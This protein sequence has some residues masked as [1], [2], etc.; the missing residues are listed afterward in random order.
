MTDYQ[1]S[2]PVYLNKPASTDCNRILSIICS[3]LNINHFRTQQK[4]S[5]SSTFFFFSSSCYWKSRR[6]VKRNRISFERNLT[7]KFFFSPSRCLS[8]SSDTACQRR[9]IMKFTRLW[10]W[11]SM[12]VLSS[13]NF[14]YNRFNLVLGN[15]NRRTRTHTNETTNYLSNRSIKQCGCWWN[16]TGGKLSEK[17]V[18]GFESIPH[19]WPWIVSIRKRMKDKPLG[20]PICGERER[21]R[22]ISNRLICMFLG[23]TLIS[24][25]HILTAAHCKKI[26]LT[27][28]WFSLFRSRFL[29]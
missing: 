14:A 17:I 11:I 3:L 12:L 18:G 26:R 1:T 23:G 27:K 29:W 2:S 28:N 24:D 15:E 22:L 25:R 4:P 19:S 13:F 10:K 20:L 8:I 16:D 5:L 6:Y 21:E 7:P 9:L